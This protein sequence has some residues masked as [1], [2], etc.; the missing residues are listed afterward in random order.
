MRQILRYVVSLML[1]TLVMSIAAF[2]Q[3]PSLG[4]IARENRNKKAAEESSSTPPRVITNKNLP[5][6]PDASTS[7]DAS[8][9]PSTSKTDSPFSEKTAAQSSNERSSTEQGPAV[10][11]STVHIPTDLQLAEQHAARQRANEHRAADQWKR[12]ILQQ[13]ATVT[14]LRMRAD[15]LGASIHFANVSTY[16]DMPFNRYQARQIDRLRQAQQQL[17]EQQRKLEDMQEAAR[18]AGMHT[19]VYDP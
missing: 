5:K 1:A 13:E 18:H 19:V 3:S 11:P 17:G 16:N 12:R 10:H 6:D 2:G 7:D 4:D 8:A 15:R 14:N 9:T